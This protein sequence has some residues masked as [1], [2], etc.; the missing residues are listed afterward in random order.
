MKTTQLEKLIK[1]ALDANGYTSDN[2]PSE[3]MASII[4]FEIIEAGVRPPL[5]NV[6]FLGRAADGQGFMVKRLDTGVI[7]V[8][9]DVRWDAYNLALNSPDWE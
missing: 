1:D 9:Q 8:V 7:D 6:Q 5:K 4:A 3:E 2:T